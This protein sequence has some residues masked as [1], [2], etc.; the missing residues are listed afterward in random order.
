MNNTLI[1][2]CFGYHTTYRIVHITHGMVSVI[3]DHFTI[4]YYIYSRRFSSTIEQQKMPKILDN[5]L[6][7]L[8][9]AKAAKAV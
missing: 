9:A 1:Y 7:K 8:E 2:N 6:E 3:S 5:Q 4:H